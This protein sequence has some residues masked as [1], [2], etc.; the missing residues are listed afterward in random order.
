M[1]TTPVTIVALAIILFSYAV[2]MPST[3]PH[4]SRADKMKKERHSCRID[5]WP[6]S[7]GRH[8]NPILVRISMVIL[9]SEEGTRQGP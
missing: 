6:L 7:A 3:G 9:D 1:D 4:C 8:E 2:A 5:M